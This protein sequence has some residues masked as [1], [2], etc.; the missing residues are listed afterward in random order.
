MSKF[1]SNAIYFSAL[2]IIIAFFCVFFFKNNFIGNKFSGDSD[3]SEGWIYEEDGSPVDFEDLRFVGLDGRVII[4]KS[5]SS[6]EL[7]GRMLSFSSNN[8]VFDVYLGGTE[9]YDFHPGLDGIAGKYYGRF[10]HYVHFPDFEGTKELSIIYSDLLGNSRWTRFNDL[11]LAYPDEIMRIH[12]RQNIVPFLICAITFIFGLGIS[13]IGAFSSGDRT[14]TIALG[15]FAMMLSAWTNSQTGF[16]ELISDNTAAARVIEYMSLVL[17]P[18]PCVLYMA[19]MCRAQNSRA[20]NSVVAAA[21]INAAAQVF[22]VLFLDLDYHDTLILSHLVILY[23]VGVLVFICVRALRDDIMN[24]EQRKYLLTA[25]SIVV[26]TGAADML[27]YYI[28]HRE[29]SARFTRIGLLVFVVIL[30]NYELKQIISASVND[31]ELEL[32]RQVATTDALTGLK[33]RA[34]FEAF[35]KGAAHRKKGRCCVIHM[36]VN[37]LKTVNDNHGHEEGDKHLR[38]AAEIIRNSFGE[39]GDAYRTGGDEYIAFIEG[40]DCLEK[41]ETA[42]EKFYSLEGLYNVNNRPPVRMEIALGMSL[43]EFGINDLAEAHR[44]ADEQMYEN[45]DKLKELR[46]QAKR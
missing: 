42:K 15:T 34:A 30:A 4:T 27:F 8:L 1:H 12:I 11:S 43:C 7:Q 23:G 26:F 20:V 16:M 5:I 17:L 46:K 41:Y 44:L 38:G 3:F 2:V 14:G 6:S 22:A 28:L 10:T 9:I 32:M 37:C 36:D 45:K 33:N 31:K 39:Y 29:D 19:Y 35:E 40:N 24:K 18:I 25:F 21:L 13:I